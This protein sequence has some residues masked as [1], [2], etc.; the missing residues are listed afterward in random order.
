MKLQEELCTLRV[1]LARLSILNCEFKSSSA[2][3]GGAIYLK[4]GYKA[5]CQIHNTTF[6]LNEAKKDGGAIYC[7]NFDTVYLKNENAY[8]NYANNNG[9]FAY[10]LNSKIK[11]G[12]INIISCNKASNGGAMYICN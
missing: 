12:D 1:V 5:A 9:G 11:I 7:N 4:N 6:T 2:H 3:Y 10:L 8:S